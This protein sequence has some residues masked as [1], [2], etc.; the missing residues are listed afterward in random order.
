MIK[1]ILLVT[2]ARSGTH[3]VKEML[4]N[5]MINAHAPDISTD[6]DLDEINFVYNSD[7]SNLYT[8]H[9]EPL[10][11]WG[12][13][14]VDRLN[15]IIKNREIYVLFLDRID[16]NE[17]VLSRTIVSMYG[18][19]SNNPKI[20]RKIRIKRSALEAEYRNLTRVKYHNNLD[21]IPLTVHQKIYY[22]DILEN[23]L[24]VD[25]VDIPFVL[26]SNSL[27][28]VKNP[29][30]KDAI[31]NYDEVLKWMKQLSEK[32]NKEWQPYLVWGEK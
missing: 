12:K 31:R 14:K 26:D 7:R 16:F 20:K 27:A 21:K 29:S 11:H 28:V 5:Y 9:F 15:T 22:E 1:N 24:C 18:W 3:M 10:E 4:S 6:P 23:G 30:K 13:S 25:G 32:Y 19:E 17:Q 2:T 8:M